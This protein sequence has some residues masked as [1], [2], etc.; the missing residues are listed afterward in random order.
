MLTQYAF[1][2]ILTSSNTAFLSESGNCEF[3]LLAKD[4]IFLSDAPRKVPDIIL[5]PGNRA[6]V[7]VRCNQVGREY[8]NATDLALRC[9][10]SY[11]CFDPGVQPLQNE[12]Y[13]DVPKFVGTF[14]DPELQPTI[15]VI[16]VSSPDPDLENFTA[17]TP[18]YLVDLQDVDNVDGNFTNEYA[19]TNPDQTSGTSP[20]DAWPNVATP[21]DICGVHGPYGV[22]GGSE[23]IP[24]IND[25]IFINDFAAGSVQEIGEWISF[26][27]Q[28]VT[29]F[30]FITSLANTSSVTSLL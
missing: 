9:T 5:S 18:C 13:P 29:S 3:Q 4:G 7:A 16:D 30:T 10:P 12:E 22:G 24:F 27:S 26:T 28:I 11:G 1:C 25:T 23:I 20:E 19:C 17:P 2:I 14:S 21:L 15:F 6:D 8:M